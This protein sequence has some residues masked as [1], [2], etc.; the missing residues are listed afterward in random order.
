MLEGTKDSDKPADGRTVRGADFPELPPNCRV[1]FYNDS[2]TPKEFVVA[3]LA[4]IFE[5]EPDEAAR[6]T[7]FIHENGAAVVGMYTYDIAVSL[8]NFTTVRARKEGFPLH[9]EVAKA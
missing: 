5:K 2:F 8:A 6:L 3:V 7:D 1:I 4:S 9:L